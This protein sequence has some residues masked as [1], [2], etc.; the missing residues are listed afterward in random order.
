MKSLTTDDILFLHENVRKM[1][2][3]GITKGHI[4]R[5]A[6]DGITPM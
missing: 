2:P 3:D 6:V 1:Y 4:D 5:Q